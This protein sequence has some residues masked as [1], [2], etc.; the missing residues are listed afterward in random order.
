M[1]SVKFFDRPTCTI[2]IQHDISLVGDIKPIRQHFHRV[3]PAKQRILDDEV[4]YLLYSGLAKPSYSS[5]ATPCLL[6]GKPDGTYRFCTDYRKLNMVTKPDSFPLPRMDDCTDMVGSARY[7]SKFDL[8]KGYYQVLLTPRAQ[9]LSAFVTPSGM[10]SYSFMSFWLR[11]A[12]STF[13]R[14]MNW[15]ISGLNGCT[16]NT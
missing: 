10:Y 14:L 15:V 13:Q 8:L 1:D 11:N 16:V 4:Q 12:Q 7:V 6:V 5:W 9:E 3:S 2:W